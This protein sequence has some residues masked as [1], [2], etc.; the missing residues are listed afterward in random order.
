MLLNCFFCN[1]IM[2]RL[3]EYIDNTRETLRR[4]PIEGSSLYQKGV[5]TV[6]LP[7]AKQDFRI[8][9]P[10]LVA[11][12]QGKKPDPSPRTLEIVNLRTPNPKVDN[13]VP[14][15]SRFSVDPQTR[16]IELALYLS[17]FREWRGTLPRADQYDPELLKQDMM[18]P[19]NTTAIPVTKDRYFILPGRSAGRQSHA[20]GVLCGLN[21]YRLNRDFG[22]NT[23]I[24]Q[25]EIIRDG[26]GHE[27]VRQNRE[28]VAFQLNIPVSK[29]THS[30]LVGMSVSE[31]AIADYG[32]H[33]LHIATIDL[34]KQ[35]VVEAANGLYG[36][37]EHPRYIRI[38]EDKHVFPFTPDSLVRLANEAPEIM[39]MTQI[40]LLWMALAVKFGESYLSGINGLQRR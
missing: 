23:L 29:V 31:P 25:G 8:I 14:N 18:L 5:G 6:V 16:R 1:Y 22:P 24:C 17:T 38:E 19:F 37:N 34:D 9:D 21:G 32:Y 36:N 40:P 7:A 2:S 35:E 3:Q 10:G 30:D 20:G 28:C 13:P 11:V 33:T 12:V 27:L 15:L 39:A 4:Y 26:T